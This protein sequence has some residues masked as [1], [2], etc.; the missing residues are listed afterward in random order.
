MYIGLLHLV[1]EVTTPV[2]PTTFTCPFVACNAAKCYFLLYNDTHNPVRP[3]EPSHFKLYAV[4]SA[5]HGGVWY[6]YAELC[7][8]S[9]HVLESCI[10]EKGP[11]CLAYKLHFHEHSNTVGALIDAHIENL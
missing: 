4:K 3:C 1:I 8:Y 6:K 9:L 10:P 5:L 11:Q 7:V 2:H